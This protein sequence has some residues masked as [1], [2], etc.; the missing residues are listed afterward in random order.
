MVRADADGQ[1]L[2]AVEAL[3][4]AAASIPA[5]TRDG[6]DAKAAMLHR[7]LHGGT[8][9]EMV[10]NAAEADLALAYSVIGDSLALAGGA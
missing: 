5:I 2:R 9:Q 3:A 7:H 8:V 6:A 4:R 1:W 10:E